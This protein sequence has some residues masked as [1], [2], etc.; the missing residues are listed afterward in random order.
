VALY[1]YTA[2]ASEGYIPLD[3]YPHLRAWIARIE[4]LPGF[5]P[6]ART[7]PRFGKAAQ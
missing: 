3:P 7:E 5:I 2:H 1:S 4:A 6:M